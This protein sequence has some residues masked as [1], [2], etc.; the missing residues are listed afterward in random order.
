MNTILAEPTVT[1]Y[2]RDEIE[3]TTVFTQAGPSTF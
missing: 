3:S 1:T 2:D